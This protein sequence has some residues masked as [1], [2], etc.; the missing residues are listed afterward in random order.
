MVDELG[1]EKFGAHGGDW[2]STVTEHLARS[3]AGSV[4][5][6][7][8]TDA[9]FWHVFQKPDKLSTAE[10]KYLNE[11]E[12]FQ[13]DGGVYALIQGTRPRTAAPALNDLPAGL[14]PPTSSK[15]L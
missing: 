10:R 15:V 8:L 3:Y 1:Y 13:E 9:P 14:Q 12:R 4:V 2:G 11:F 5:G 6:I 7:H